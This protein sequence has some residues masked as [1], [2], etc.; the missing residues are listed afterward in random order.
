M[1]SNTINLNGTFYTP[2]SIQL[3][4]QIYSSTNCKGIKLNG[5]V[6]FSFSGGGGGGGKTPLVPTGY[7]HLAIFR[8]LFNW[9]QAEIEDK[10]LLYFPYAGVD[11]AIRGNVDKRYEFCWKQGDE[12]TEQQTSCI[13]YIINDWSAANIK[14]S[15]TTENGVDIVDTQVMKKGSENLRYYQ[16]Y[17]GDKD[18]NDFITYID[19]ISGSL[20]E[21]DSKNIAEQIK[22]RYND[23]GEDRR[24]FINSYNGLYGRIKNN[25]IIISNS[26]AMISFDTQRLYYIAGY[27]VFS[28]PDLSDVFNNNEP[29]NIYL[30]KYY[31]RESDINAMLAGINDYISS[32]H[33]DINQITIKTI[34]FTEL[35]QATAWATVFAEQHKSEPSVVISSAGDILAAFINNNNNNNSDNFKCIDIAIC[36]NIPNYSSYLYNIEYSNDLNENYKWNINGGDTYTPFTPN[37]TICYYIDLEKPNQNS[38]LTNSVF[39]NYEDTSVDDSDFLIGGINYL[40]G[41][42]GS[43]HPDDVIFSSI[44]ENYNA[45]INIDGPYNKLNIQQLSQ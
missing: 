15:I 11:G 5:N 12:R 6:V 36:P 7:A 35:G 14:N 4:D 21:V 30:V 8:P 27:S 13:N 16:L 25:D 40:G 34:E 43:L 24:F 42:D 45:D 19:D 9:I 33:S 39:Y 20:T 26:I 18:I 32:E 44:V 2:T 38:Q 1:A 3:D 31:D 41:E 29:R 23:L 17:N 37:N 10:G 22:V 28:S